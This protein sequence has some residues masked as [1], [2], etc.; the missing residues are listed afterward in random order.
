[1]SL[2]AQGLPLHKWPSR[3]MMMGHSGVLE[4]GIQHS[5]LEE[6]KQFPIN[7]YYPCSLNHYLPTCALDDDQ[8]EDVLSPPKGTVQGAS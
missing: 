5:E 3:Q 7:R 8:H 4:Q 1:V 6:L 2:K